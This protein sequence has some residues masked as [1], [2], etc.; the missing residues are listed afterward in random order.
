VAALV[1][2]DLLRL[3]VVEEGVIDRG[4]LLYLKREAEVVLQGRRHLG[5]LA[6]SD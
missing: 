4:D 5:A 3:L 6:T 2:I 1:P